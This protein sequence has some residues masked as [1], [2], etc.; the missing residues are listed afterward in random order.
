MWQYMSFWGFINLIFLLGVGTFVIDGVMP[1]IQWLLLYIACH[2]IWNPLTRT[3]AVVEKERVREE[4]MREK[5][6]RRYVQKNT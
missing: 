5:M 3:Q 2:C 6:R 1:K 4:D